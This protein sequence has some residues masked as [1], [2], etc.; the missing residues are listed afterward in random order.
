MSNMS[1]CEPITDK[2][3]TFTLQGG[4]QKGMKKIVSLALSTA[5][6]LSMF[7]SVTSAATMTTQEKY[8]ALVTQGI[9][10]GYPDGNAY[11][12]KDMTRAEF[13]KVVALLTGLDT[14]ATGTNSYQDQNYA[15]AWYKPYVEAVT[16]AGYMKGTSTGAKK[17]FN[18][19]G[20]VTVQEMAATLVRAAKLEVPTTGI[21]NTA[22]AWAKGEVQAAINAGLVPATSNFTAAATRGLLVDTAYAFQTAVNKPAVASYEVQDN[23]ATV[24]F[25]LANGEK[26]TV[27]PEKALV[28]NTATTVN[29][30]YG[31]FEYSE[32]VTWTVTDATEASSAAATNLKQVMVTFNG[33]VSASSAENINNY[34]V[35]GRTI[36][37]ADLSEDGR[38]VTLLLAAETDGTNSNTLV[39]NRETNV[40]VRNIMPSTGTTALATKT[41]AF[42]PADVAV[43]T[44][45][46]VKGLGTR[47]FQVTFSEPVR[48]SDLRAANFTVDGRAIAGTY[49]YAYPNSVI[50]E[51]PLTEGTH[52]VRI[53]G[54]SDYSGLTMVP[55]EQTF[56]VAAD[57]AVAKAV[58][59]VATDLNRVVVTFDKPVKSVSGAY[60]NV[61]GNTANTPITVNGNRVTLNFPEGKTLN[62][63]ANNIVLSNVLDYSGNVGSASVSVTPTF[64]LVAPTV[65]SVE[66]SQEGTTYFAEINLSKNVTLASAQ[67]LS[68]YVL[69]NSRGEVVTGNGRNASGNPT[70]TPTL[71]N[72]GRT[73]RVNLGANLNDTFYTLT[74]SGLRDVTVAGNVLLPYTATLDRNAA[75]TGSIVR[76]WA[77]A[78]YVYVEFNKAVATSGAGNALDPAKYV[79]DGAAGTDGTNR[80]TTRSADVETYGANTV[81]IYARNFSGITLVSRQVTANYVADANGTYFQNANGG[82]AVTETINAA[83]ERPTVVAADGTVDATS[84]S[85]VEVTFTAPLAS[86]RASDFTLY[87]TTTNTSITAVGAELSNNNR[88]VTLNFNSQIPAGFADGD[89]QLRIADTAGTVDQFGNAATVGTVANGSTLRT[90]EVNNEIRPSVTTGPVVQGQTVASA[91]ERL[92]TLRFTATQD[93][94]AGTNSIAN[95]AFSVNSSTGAAVS[96]DSVDVTAGNANQFDVVVRAPRTATVGTLA[97]SL[98]GTTN[99]QSR[100]IVATGTNG[101]ALAGFDS[102]AVAIDSLTAAPTVTAAAVNA[103]GT[104]VTVTFN[105]NVVPTTPTASQFEVRVNNAVV[106]TG[107]VT[108]TTDN[109]Y[110]IAITGTPVV[111]GD[112]VTLAYTP[113]TTPGDAIVTNAQLTPVAAFASQAVTNGLQ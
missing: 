76:S 73:V 45:T 44:V 10:A 63:G 98:N 40:V 108:R 80:L 43:P 18:P 109:T 48:Q 15:N 66:F 71:I 70:T 28:A 1:E 60:A 78:G 26:V 16:K 107:A 112:V 24:V 21:N 42:T 72:N 47:A 67:T 38:V 20:K 79:I 4:E 2:K 41:L 104:A 111:A 7:A 29:F 58:S 46:E 14:A 25:T 50:V 8:N 23:G 68:N 90:I 34:T 30:K 95:G 84:T 100:F 39:A 113:S 32:S 59:A 88:T 12:D 54:V 87:N 82:Y 96:I 92:I 105:Q 6:A 35:S 85:N 61:T 31:E 9:F 103:A 5:M 89:L 52:T 91:T 53:S 94:Q 106:T 49:N 81:R 64:D 102:R 33:K 51:T 19:N 93:L 57:T 55:T 101:P 75:A 110:S 11:L 37:R 56:T 62:Y 13:A 69:K 77:Q 83:N 99:E 65:T 36:E 74:V 86:V 3:N 22:A 97:V 17:L 27:K